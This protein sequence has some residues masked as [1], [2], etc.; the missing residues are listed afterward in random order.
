[1][2]EAFWR[3]IKKLK[4]LLRVI[5]L[6]VSLCAVLCFGGLLFPG[7]FPV[8]VLGR[9]PLTCLAIMVV[10]NGCAVLFGV[11]IAQG[12]FEEFLSDH[13]WFVC[14][15][16]GYVLEGLPSQHRCPECDLPYDRGALERAWKAWI[17]R[18]I[19]YSASGG[20]DGTAEEGRDKQTNAE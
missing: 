13:S 18:S 8:H 7:A 20:E 11:R 5:L 4:I 12:R 16:C 19:V 14:Y 10:L 6:L 2:P 17:A 3:S 9:Y 15:R 1:M